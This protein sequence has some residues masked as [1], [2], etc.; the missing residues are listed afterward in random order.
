MHTG[1]VNTEASVSSA[2]LRAVINAPVHVS[3]VLFFVVIGRATTKRPYATACNAVSARPRRPLGRGFC[4]SPVDLGP[5]KP[6]SGN[7][8]TGEL[9]NERGRRSVTVADLK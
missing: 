9:I 5:R 6:I 3:D 4:R 8:R 2:R 1:S 7:A